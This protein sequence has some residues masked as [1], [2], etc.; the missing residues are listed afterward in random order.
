MAKVLWYD[1]VW[2]KKYWLSN[3][4]GISLWNIGVNTWTTQVWEL[5]YTILAD[6]KDVIYYQINTLYQ[7]P[8]VVRRL[9]WVG[10]QAHIEELGIFRISKING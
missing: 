5:L 2:V 3:Q 6:M 4:F 8:L 10:G 1:V 7:Q 9:V